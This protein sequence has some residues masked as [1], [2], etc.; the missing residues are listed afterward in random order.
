MRLPGL[1]AAVGVAAGD[2]AK[3]LYSQDYVYARLSYS[4]LEE[5]VAMLKHRAELRQIT[6]RFW[7]SPIVPD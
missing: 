2:A 7:P 1:E 3:H 6:S 5:A 4:S